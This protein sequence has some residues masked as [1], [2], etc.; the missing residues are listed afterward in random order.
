MTEPR[1]VKYAFLAPPYPKIKPPVGKSGPG[2]IL[3]RSSIEISGLSTYARHASK[4][5]PKLCGAILVAI[6]TA[7]PLVPFTNK[8]GYLAGKTVGSCKLSS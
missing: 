4:T 8:F 3:I 7:I 5:S 2:T 1:P 6:P